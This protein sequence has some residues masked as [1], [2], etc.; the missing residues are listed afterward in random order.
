MQTLRTGLTVAETKLLQ[1]EVEI[2]NLQE[3]NKTLKEAVENIA[4][5][6]SV[7]SQHSFQHQP[8]TNG[9]KLLMINLLE[10]MLYHCFLVFNS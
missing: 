6:S 7:S 2:E 1:R 5:K 4:E 3:Q 8:I 10:R 9:S